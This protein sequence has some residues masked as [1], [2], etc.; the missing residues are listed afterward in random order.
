MFDQV[1]RIYGDYDAM[2]SPQPAQPQGQDDGMGS[3][4][5]LGG[6]GGFGGDFGGGFDDMGDM[7]LGEPGSEGESDLSG[8]AETDLGG[9]PAADEGQPLME[10][11]KRK[12]KSFTE[13][14][15]DLLSKNEY[16]QSVNEMKNASL[17]IDLKQETIFRD[18]KNIF[19]DLSS[20]NVDGTP[21]IIEE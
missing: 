15:F 9:A 8:G 16:D 2:N 7:G 19:D 18:M 5:G 6:G 12:V 3:M 13:R 11:K 21:E 14:Y 20:E 17:D 10:A 4:G 1:D